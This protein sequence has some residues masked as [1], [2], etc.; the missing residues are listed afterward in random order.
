MHSI[1]LLF[2]HEVGKCP[3]GY[4]CDHRDGASERQHLGVNNYPV[5]RKSPLVLGK[6]KAMGRSQV[7]FD[8]ILK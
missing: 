5:D 8:L 6:R 1:I 3:P 4:C 7:K 2:R